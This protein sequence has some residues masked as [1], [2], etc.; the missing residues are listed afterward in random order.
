MFNL[1]HIFRGKKNHSSFKLKGPYSFFSDAQHK[2]DFLGKRSLG[3]L[4][5][6]LFILYYFYLFILLGALLVGGP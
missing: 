3:Y 1:L 2:S 5:C 4:N 6:V